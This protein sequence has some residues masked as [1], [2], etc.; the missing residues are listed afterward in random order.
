M[1]QNPCDLANHNNRQ[2][3]CQRSRLKDYHCGLDDLN[4]LYSKVY[5]AKAG[6]GLVSD[7]RLPDPE[8]PNWTA[9][10]V[11]AF[12]AFPGCVGIVTHGR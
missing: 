6:Q 11:L 10:L 7:D 8:R 9:I 4:I 2:L 5:S 12:V 1:R 3:L